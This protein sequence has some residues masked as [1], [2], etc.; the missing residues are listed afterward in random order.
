MKPTKI[1]HIEVLKRN[2]IIKLFFPVDFFKHDNGVYL[3]IKF[4]NST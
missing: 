2:E 4:V 3:S 1:I